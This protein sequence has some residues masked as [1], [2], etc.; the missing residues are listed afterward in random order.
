VTLKNKNGKKKQNTLPG[1]GKRVMMLALGGAQAGMRKEPELSGCQRQNG[2]W[3][4]H[5]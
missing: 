5:F 3:L 2:I 4:S 1:E